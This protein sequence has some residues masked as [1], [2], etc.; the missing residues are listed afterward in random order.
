MCKLGLL[1]K[2]VYYLLSSSF[3]ISFI[4][5]VVFIFK[6]ST[7]WGWSHFFLSSSSFFRSIFEAAFIFEVI[8]I[9]EV[10]LI[11]RGLCPKLNQKVGERRISGGR[12]WRIVLK[13]GMLKLGPDAPTISKNQVI[14]MKNQK[15]AAYLALPPLRS[16]PLLGN[17]ARCRTSSYG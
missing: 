5:L 11:S 3:F 7:F 17:V 9:L 13:L 1:N 14:W 2:V 6:S 8:L 10:I 4:L 16:R 15:M 12:S